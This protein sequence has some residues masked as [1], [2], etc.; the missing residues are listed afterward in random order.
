[1]SEQNFRRRTGDQPMR[2]PAESSNI[3]HQPQICAECGNTIFSNVPNQHRPTCVHY[4]L[5]NV[6]DSL[7]EDDSF[8]IYLNGMNLGNLDDA[9]LRYNGEALELFTA[10]R[11][12]FLGTIEISRP[13]KDRNKVMASLFTSSSVAE[14][15]Y[16]KL[17]KSRS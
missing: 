8:E 4:K 2:N 5:E 3:Q 11:K 7:T 17:L 9:N 16:Q 10:L 13:W 15:G 12:S 1:M 6:F 14:P